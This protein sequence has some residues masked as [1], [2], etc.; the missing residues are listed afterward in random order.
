MPEILGEAVDRLIT[1]ELK[2]RGMP[3]GF[4]AALYDAAR[5]EGGGEPLTARAARLLHGAAKP[6]SA[7]FILT[8]AGYPPQMPKGESDGPPGS[9]VLARML[10]WG[11]G[12]V[13][14]YVCEAKHAEPIQAASEAAA[15]MIHPAE[16]AVGRGFGGA[17]LTAPDDAGAVAA[18]AADLFER[19]RPAAL[20][21]VER[22]GPAADGVIYNATGQPKGPETR[23]VDL[24]PVVAEAA[25]RGVPSIGIG[26]H[27]NEMGFGRIGEAVRRLLP[28]GAVNACTVAT[29]VLLPCMM[30]NWGAYGIA[31][32]LG[33]ML[34]RPDVVHTAEQ[35]RAIV[36]ACL[37]AGGL[38]AHMCTKR[39]IVDGADGE[40]SMAVAQL[41]N[42]MVRLAL[43]R[44]SRGVAH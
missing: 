34:G 37:Q 27:G 2:N 15:V 44:P 17:I 10:Y 8:G 7:V 35:D 39:F 16:L 13:P 26:D 14:I 30:S 33:F 11:C 43:D 38:E 25:A 5:E 9:A 3:H 31:A 4:L 20:V 12:A 21:T 28:F 1:V 19:W 18:W 32:V 42:N 22:L 24:T 40:S 29:D 6:G 36:Q 41:L 23:I